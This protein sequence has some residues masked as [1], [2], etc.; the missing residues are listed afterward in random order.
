M[1]SI[2]PSRYNSAMNQQRIAIVRL[3]AL[4][5]IINSVV[6]LQFIRQ[7]MPDARID[8]IT[9]TPFAPLL[10]D[11]PLIDAVHAV[12]LKQIKR[13]KSLGLLRRT[14]R[15]LRAIGPYDRIIDLQ[16]LFKSAIVARLAGPNV[17][18]FDAA[19]SREGI[20]ARFY[21][22]RSAISYETNV[23]SRNCAL[24]GD[25][26]GFVITEEMV[27]SKAPALPLGPRP[28]FQEDAP[29][30]AVIVGASWPSKCYP[31]ARL[32]EV[33]AAMPLP[34]VLVWGSEKEHDNAASIAAQCPNA[35]VAPALDL[36][37]L[38]DLVGHAALTLGGDTGPT[39]LAWALNRPSVVLFGPTTPR[40]MFETP[41]N[42]A[43]ESPSKVDILAIDKSDMSIAEIPPETVITAMLELL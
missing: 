16:G 30:I 35:A 41:R 10:R 15:M 1:A 39:H 40:M 20:A 27:R 13:E 42:V 17:H 38:R 19:S 23:I 22:S 25:A 6:V 21:R 43:I 3:S 4:G 8:W 36:P 29:Y 24:V 5:D 37:A 32:A 11:H 2:S 12:P 18:G 14:V 7:A 34:C 26:L 28:V 9:E 33:C 31:P